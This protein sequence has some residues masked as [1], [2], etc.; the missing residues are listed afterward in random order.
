MKQFF[1]NMARRVA[2]RTMR[3][4]TYLSDTTDEYGGLIDRFMEYDHEL[5]RLKA[6]VDELR[7]DNRRVVELYDLVVD[8]LRR[9]RAAARRT[10]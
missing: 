6:E 5:D 2:P 9:E 1:G 10:P 4:L 8:E 7:R 3:S